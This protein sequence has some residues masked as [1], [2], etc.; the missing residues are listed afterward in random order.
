[1]VANDL[2]RAERA[3]FLASSTSNFEAKAISSACSDSLFS[4]CVFTSCSFSCDAAALLSRR[5]RSAC[6]VA[7]AAATAVDALSSF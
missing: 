3:L 7:A 1:M 2:T 4:S 6:S 5:H